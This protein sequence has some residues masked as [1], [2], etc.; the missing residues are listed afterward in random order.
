MRKVGVFSLFN[1]AGP[2]ISA[3]GGGYVK[4]GSFMSPKKVKKCTKKH[5]AHAK[6]LFSLLFVIAI[7]FAVTN[8]IAY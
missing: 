6:L 2:T 8:I 3:P 4:L 5:D 1:S 7:L